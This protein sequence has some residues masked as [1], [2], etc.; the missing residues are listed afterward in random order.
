MIAIVRPDGSRSAGPVSIP[1]APVSDR[2]V[3][4]AGCV[5]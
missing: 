2:R 1:M 5:P 3:F 4:G